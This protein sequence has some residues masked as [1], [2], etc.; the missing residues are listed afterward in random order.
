MEG[1]YQPLVLAG[2]KGSTTS[3]HRRGWLPKLMNE[4]AK[5]VNLAEGY[6]NTNVTYQNQ[7]ALTGLS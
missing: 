3:S 7:P 2:I 4:L 5:T 6:P 1:V